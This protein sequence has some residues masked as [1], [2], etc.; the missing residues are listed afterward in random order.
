MNAR[1][2]LLV[3]RWASDVLVV[4]FW[5]VFA[6]TDVLLLSQVRKRVVRLH[7]MVAVREAE[8]RA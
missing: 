3:L 8:C 1:G 4:V 5:E 7:V 6:R 2:Q